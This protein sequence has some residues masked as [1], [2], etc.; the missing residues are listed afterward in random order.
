MVSAVK[1]A[2]ARFFRVNVEPSGVGR[3]V[4][5]AQLELRAQL[6][7]AVVVDG[8]R[9][10][11]SVVRVARVVNVPAVDA[12]ARLEE[13]GNLRAGGLIGAQGLIRGSL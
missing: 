1:V 4:A 2:V 11:P 9:L 8:G 7:R 5:R 13:G 3:V 12:F 6:G 10:G